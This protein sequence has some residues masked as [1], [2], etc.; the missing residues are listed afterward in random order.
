V[1]LL[2]QRALYRRAGQGLAPA[3]AVL[4]TAQHRP[5]REPSAQGVLISEI[6]TLTMTT[7]LR[8]LHQE[9]S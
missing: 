6:A 4:Q 1:M 9:A 3:E 7:A 5:L 2:L 8:I